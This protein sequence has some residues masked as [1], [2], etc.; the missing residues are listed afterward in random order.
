MLYLKGKRH[1]YIFIEKVTN[2]MQ[3]LLRNV[4]LTKFANILSYL[5]V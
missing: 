1:F 2:S 4:A 3:Q 5:P